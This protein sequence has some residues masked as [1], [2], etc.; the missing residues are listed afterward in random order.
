MWDFS[1]AELPDLNPRVP[2]RRLTVSASKLSARAFGI[3]IFSPR[4][5]T[6]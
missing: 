2:H 3:V 6:M 4:T 5:V 1:S